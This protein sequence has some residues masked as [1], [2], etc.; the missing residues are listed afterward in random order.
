MDPWG[1]KMKGKAYINIFNKNLYC[2]AGNQ[3]Y[4]RKPYQNEWYESVFSIEEMEFAI[5]HGLMIPVE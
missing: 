3:V 4:V 5:S 1:G 2:A